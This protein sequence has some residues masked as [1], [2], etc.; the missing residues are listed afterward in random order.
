MLCIILMAVAVTVRYTV[1]G[2]QKKW[3]IFLGFGFSV[4]VR[5]ITIIL[6]GIVLARLQVKIQTCKIRG[7]GTRIKLGPISL[8]Y[9]L[10]EKKNA[11]SINQLSRQSL[12]DFIKMEGTQMEMFNFLW[13]ILGH[14]L[15]LTPTKNNW[16]P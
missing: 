11:I 14:Y 6:Y 16:P 2:C 1:Q 4:N 7:F 9:Q 3:E 13:L 10:K 8:A 12:G 15:P 5:F